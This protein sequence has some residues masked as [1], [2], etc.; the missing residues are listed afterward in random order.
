MRPDSTSTARS[1][2]LPSFSFWLFLTS[3]PMRSLA[4]FEQPGRAASV[5]RATLWSEYSA[6]PGA[7]LFVSWARAA[8][9]RIEAAEALVIISICR[10]IFCLSLFCF[11]LFNFRLAIRDCAQHSNFSTLHNSLVLTFV[12]GYE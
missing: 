3:I 4:F 8:N 12:D 10:F 1:S 7:L 9:A 11:V 6:A 2:T 5:P